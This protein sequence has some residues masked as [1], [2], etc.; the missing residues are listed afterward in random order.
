MSMLAEPTASDASERLARLLADYR[1]LP[2]VYDEMVDPD[3]EV[4]A[5]WRGLLAGLA[6]SGGRNCRAASPPPGA[7]CA[8]PG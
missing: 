1:P 5:H 4:R 8:I 2:G 6:G 3:G 7:I